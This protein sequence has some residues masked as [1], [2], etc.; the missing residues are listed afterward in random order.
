MKTNIF[1]VLMVA[2]AAIVVV[3]KYAAADDATKRKCGQII[4]DSDAV[5]EDVYAAYLACELGEG[6][7]FAS[8]K[9]AADLKRQNLAALGN[10]IPISTGVNGNSGGGGSGSVN[11]FCQTGVNCTGAC[12]PGSN[13]TGVSSTPLCPTGQNC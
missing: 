5:S 7:L 3:E 9:D 8:A 11:N 4:A 6:D 2:L 12:L 1:L 13:C 10:I